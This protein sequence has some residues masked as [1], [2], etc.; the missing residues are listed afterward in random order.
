[1]LKLRQPH[2]LR[3]VDK[4]LESR[5]PKNL[6]YAPG[7]TVGFPEVEAIEVAATG[8]LTAAGS[9]TLGAAVLAGEPLGTI[10]VGAATGGFYGVVVGGAIGAAIPI[11]PY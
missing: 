9:A 2:F 10:A 6:N 5:T 3:F 4:C 1:M 8:S 7:H 11:S